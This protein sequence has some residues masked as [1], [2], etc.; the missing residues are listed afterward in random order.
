VSVDR[1]A[2]LREFQQASSLRF[3]SIAL[4]NLSFIHRSCRNENAALQGNNERLEFLG[5]AVLGMIAAERLYDIAAGRTEGELARIKSFVVSENTLATLALRIGI[6]KLLLMGKG[7]EMSGGRGKKAILADA[8][9]ALLGALFLDSGYAEVRRFVL[10]LLDPEIE[11]VLQ[12]RHT[13][14][15]KTIIQHYLQ[16]Y[17]RSRPEY[18]EHES[19]GPDHDRRFRMSCLCLGR[20]YGPGEGKTKKDAGQEAARAVYE[21]IMAAGGLEAARLIQTEEG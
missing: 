15:Y 12:N 19:C 5:D 10:G 18:R 20:E 8:L 13:K 14:D 7:E 17:H 3:R 6:D 21:A 16:K 11:K 1:E 2:R 4:L 9:E